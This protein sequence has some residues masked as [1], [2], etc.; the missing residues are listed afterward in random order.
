M[1]YNINGALHRIDIEGDTKELKNFLSALDDVVSGGKSGLKYNIEDLE[2]IKEP[3]NFNLRHYLRIY[4]DK[5]K[6]SII[7]NVH[8]SPSLK[9]RKID[10]N[11][12]FKIIKGHFEK[13]LELVEK[14][15]TI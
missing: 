12:Y 9:Y 15:K 2:K 13:V 1:K 7:A 11:I 4:Y 6:V 10:K 14:N 5:N 8:D 3:L